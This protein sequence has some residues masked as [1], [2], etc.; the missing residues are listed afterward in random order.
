MALCNAIYLQ[1][2]TQEVTTPQYILDA[3]NAEFGPLSTFDPCPY[4][5]PKGFNGLKADWATHLEDRG[6]KGQFVYVNP[7]YN[8]IEKWLQKIHAEKDKGVKVVSLLPARTA[9]KWFHEKVLNK[10]ELRFIQGKVYFDGYDNGCP[11]GSMICIFKSPV[12]KSPEVPENPG[13]ST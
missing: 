3:L 6:E 10:C 8:D 4:P 13:S 5:R 2:R 7:P 9:T 12:A 11:W 1:S